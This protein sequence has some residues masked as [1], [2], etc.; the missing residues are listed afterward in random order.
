MQLL[1]N[2]EM[3]SKWGKMNIQTAGYTG[4]Y[5]GYIHNNGLIPSR[6]GEGMG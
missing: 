2:K 4:V 5:T 3:V 1:E 6:E